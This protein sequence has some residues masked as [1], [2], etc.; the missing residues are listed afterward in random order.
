MTHDTAALDTESQ[1]LTGSVL[2]CD[3]TSGSGKTRLLVRCA[4]ACADATGGCIL[5]YD[6]TGNV[7]TEILSQE[8]FRA[9]ALDKARDARNEAAEIEA[10]R[11]L[12][13]FRTKGRLEFYTIGEEDAFADTLR[14]VVQSR[15]RAPFGFVLIDEGG[16]ARNDRNARDAMESAMRGSMVLL[17][18]ARAFGGISSHRRMGATPE[19][20]SVLR[21]RVMWSNPDSEGDDPHERMAADRGWQVLSDAM[22][23]PGNS[24]R[25]YRGIRWNGTRPTPFQLE[26]DA[27]LPRWMYL[28][29]IPTVSSEREFVL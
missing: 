11:R 16:F 2:A 25:F 4:L 27:P 3:G 17:R 12:E 8:K 22:G 24:R 28:P 19:I 6:P 1:E 15:P 10:V 21:A 20:R 29:A 13:L 14:G 5:A 18:N 7:R 23:T 26:R 9:R